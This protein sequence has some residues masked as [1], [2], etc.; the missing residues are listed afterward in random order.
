MRSD[1]ECAFGAVEY[2]MPHILGAI[3]R[4]RRDGVCQAAYNTR[5]RS[6]DRGLSGG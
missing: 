4:G 5:G 1:S 6:E 2:P 3:F